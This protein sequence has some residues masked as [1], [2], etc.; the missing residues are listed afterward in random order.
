[1][2]SG[3]LFLTLLAFAFE[4]PFVFAQTELRLTPDEYFDSP[5]ISV[6]VFNDPYSE[7]HQGGIQIIHHGERIAANGDLRL[8]ATPGQWQA[9]S[10]LEGKTTDSLDQIITV[11]LTYPNEEAKNRRFNPVPYPDLEINYR[12]SV[13]A[14]G[15]DFRIIVDLDRPLPKKWI[16]KVGFNLE[17]FPG[18]LFGKTY[19]M[20]EKPGVFPCQLNGPFTRGVQADTFE[21]VPMSIGNQL[22]IIPENE[23][24]RISIRTEVSK[25]QLIDARALHNNGWFVVRSLVPGGTGKG[26]VEWIVSPSVIEGWQYGPVI[27]INQAGYLPKQSKKALIEADKRF[28]GKPVVELVEITT[29]GKERLVMSDT[30]QHW[31]RYQR[32][33]YFTFDFSGIQHE[34]VYFL[35][36]GRVVSEIFRIAGNAYDRGIWQP[37]LE[38]FLPVQMCHM[39]INEGYRVWHGLCHMDDA[40]MAPLNHIHFD[41]YWQDSSTLCDFRPMDHVPD[42]NVGGWHDAGD[43]DLR[44]E[45]QGGTVYALSLTYEAFRPDYDVTTIDQANHLVEMHVPDGKPDILQQIE[46]GTLTIVK[47][48]KSL[49]RLYRG[50]I[51]RDLRQYVLLGDGS[52][53]TDNVIY[54]DEGHMPEWL[55]KVNDERWIFTEINPRREL[56]VC[57]DLAAAARVLQ[58]FN[59]TLALQSLEIAEELWNKNT[60]SRYEREKVLAL[61]ELI[62]ATDQLEYT[63]ALV[64]MHGY[65]AQHVPETGWSVARILDRIDD[66]QFKRGYML[67]IQQYF[68]KLKEITSSNPFG[69]PYYPRIWGSAWGIERFGFE[70]YCMICWRSG[71]QNPI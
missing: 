71:R 3:S 65:V 8:E 63:D 39:R 10:Q 32:Y 55:G 60:G 57:A 35:R 58:G 12:V 56:Q 38:Y 59:D 46:H 68:G 19:L 20:D 43:F 67:G 42:L 34:G 49:G 50:I 4:A 62:L 24:Q 15:E 14:E 64:A 69:I 18:S 53:M 11:S 17:L 51:C 27:H 25:L 36:L 22:T 70:Q 37:T 1:M 5:S 41:G 29:D 45:S 44:V 16:G 23:M 9:F 6:I 2:K 61:V 40:R 52:T 7:G 30:A 33:N 26:A 48:Y 31:G 66:M 47:G 28:S 54:G 21:V 13:K